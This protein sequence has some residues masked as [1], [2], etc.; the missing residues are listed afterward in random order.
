[1]PSPNAWSGPVSKVRLGGVLR[2]L[3]KV[4]TDADIAYVTGI[5]LSVK[6]G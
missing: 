2:L 5:N 3:E 4:F 6:F 1:M